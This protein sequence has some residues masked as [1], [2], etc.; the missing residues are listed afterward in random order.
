MQKDLND[1]EATGTQ[2]VGISYD[3][4]ETLKSFA[5][6][7][8][9]SYPLLSDEGSKTIKAY[10]I[11]SQEGYPHPGTYLLDEEGIVQVASCCEPVPAGREW[12]PHR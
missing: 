6:Q 5:D 2:V 7:R 1:I 9:I 3:S 12:N 8:S 4:V 11:H 10:G